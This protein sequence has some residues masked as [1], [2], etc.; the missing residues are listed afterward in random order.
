MPYIAE[1][2]GP[3]NLTTVGDN[4][5]TVSLQNPL[6]VSYVGLPVK[7]VELR[8]EHGAECRGWVTLSIDP[9]GNVQVRPAGTAGSYEQCRKQ[10]NL[11]VYT[12]AGK[13]FPIPYAD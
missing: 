3:K 2:L 6:E 1:I 8:G 13:R 5:Y 11:L 9:N 4:T 12:T 7:G 10:G